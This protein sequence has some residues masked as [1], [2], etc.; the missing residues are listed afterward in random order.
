[1]GSI[2]CLSLKGAA[3]KNRT[4]KYFN[5]MSEWYNTDEIRL[6]AQWKCADVGNV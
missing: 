3:T 4:L 6:A 1:V 5:K 2:V